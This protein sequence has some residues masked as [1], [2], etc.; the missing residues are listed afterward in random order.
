MRWS[1]FR[2]RGGKEMAV[3]VAVEDN[4]ATDYSCH[5]M[6]V[7]GVRRR[8]CGSAGAHSGV[9]RMKNPLERLPQA[10]LRKMT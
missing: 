6:T 10:T 4:D 9:E 3:G 7:D 1:H 8:N 2:C 5:A